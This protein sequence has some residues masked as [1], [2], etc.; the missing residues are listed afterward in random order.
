MLLPAHRSLRAPAIV[1][2]I[3]WTLGAPAWA[4]ATDPTATPAPAAAPAAA[5]P[6]SIDEALAFV[7]EL[8]K[9]NPSPAKPCRAASAVRLEADGY[10]EIEISRESYCEHS[11]VRVHVQDIDPESV[12]ISLAEEGRVAFRCRNDESCALNFQK[13][14]KQEEGAWV[15][16]DADWLAEMPGRGSH[17]TASFSLLLSGDRRAAD[18]AAKGL[19]YV[20]RS[21]VADPVYAEPAD[22]FSGQVASAAAAPASP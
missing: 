2:C 16:R 4:Q 19:A 21:A 17:P 7:N 9:A 6:P 14:K 22:P 5:P 10:L 1:A 18:L 11:R 15:D 12:E 13:R 8:L 3:A 20:V